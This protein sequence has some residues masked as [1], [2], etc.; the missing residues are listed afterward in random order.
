MFIRTEGFKD[1]IRFYPVVSII[2]ALQVVIWLFTSLVPGWGEWLYYTGVGFNYGIEQ[3]EYWRLVTPIFLHGG[4][5]HLIFN[6]F[7]LILFAPALEQML[8]KVKFLFVYFAAGIAANVLTFFV[9]SDPFY[10]HVGASGAIFGLFGLYI[11]M[12]FFEKKLI[13]QQSAQL[14]FIIS[15]VGLVMTFLRPNIN[16]TG[17]LFGFIAG[18]ALGP[19][20]LQNVKA[21]VPRPRRPRVRPGGVGFDPNRWNKKRYRWQPYIRKII[22]WF[23]IILVALGV[24]ARFF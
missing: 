14:I 11:F 4:I 13:D 23:F 7:S 8:G 6:S 19:I 1:F 24:I 5:A 21:F 18:F 2:V 10:A 16:I 9:V 15:A 12:I 17:H 22:F 3:G 20:V